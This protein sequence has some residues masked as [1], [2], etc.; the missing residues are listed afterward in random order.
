MAHPEG[1]GR[2]MGLKVAVVTLWAEDVEKT[3]Q[4][5]RGIFGIPGDRPGS[6]GVVHLDVGGIYFTIMKGTP[7]KATNSIIPRFPIVA[8]S[9]E[10][11]EKFVQALKDNN[12]SLP[13]G[14]ERS[15][16]AR[17]VMFDDPAGNLIE[18]VEFL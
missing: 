4:F 2:T 1:P 13:W 14:V 11:L 17:W 18:L 3:A 7:G 8:F 16:A 12:V 6:G 9:V 15:P 5:Y 10:N